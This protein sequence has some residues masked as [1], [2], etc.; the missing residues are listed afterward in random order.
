MSNLSA[1]K[2]PQHLL[3]WMF[4]FGNVLSEYFMEENVK[5]KTA[6]CVQGL[7]CSV[8]KDVMKWTGVYFSDS[9]DDATSKRGQKCRGRFELF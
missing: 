6:E 3:P 1:S 5:K 7:C 2:L 4:H 9:G 8:G